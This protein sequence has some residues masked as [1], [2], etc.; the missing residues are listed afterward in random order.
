VVTN[1]IKADPKLAPLGDNGGPTQTMR[2]QPG[3]AAID[4]VPIFGA[5]CPPTDQR[6]V[7]RPGG[8]GCEIGAY[9]VT[10]PRATT[11]PATEIVPAAATLS[12]TITANAADAGVHFEYGT[13]T[14]YGRSSADQHVAGVTA[15]TVQAHLGG[16][17]PGTTYHYR[18]VAA[19]IDGTTPGA[20]RTFRT[21]I[22][23]IT[24][25]KV[26][27]RRVHR[28]RGAKVT[29]TDSEASNTRFVLSRCKKHHKKRCRRYRIVRTF[30]RHDVAGPNR[31]HLRA[32]HLAPGRYRLAATP[33]FD[34]AE[35]ATATVG[36]RIV[37]R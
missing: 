4:Q 11:G 8:T 7:T 19:S 1:F 5:A 28:K 37:R 31:F 30:S 36:F 35:G 9:E 13:T 14:A 27:P 34:G 16:L 24:R 10:P 17:A 21:P 18:V 22:A 32:K 2:P 3:S 15:V 25:L 6:G 29:Y 23:S 33:S 12:A 26:K 20:D